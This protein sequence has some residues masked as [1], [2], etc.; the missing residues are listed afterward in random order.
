MVAL[1]TL[2]APAAAVAAAGG[3]PAAVELEHDRPVR[4][5]DADRPG[6]P[7]HGKV[8]AG[9]DECRPGLAE[10]GE[11]AIGRPA[12]GDATQVEPVPG[13]ERDAGGGAIDVDA[14]TAARRCC[15]WRPAGA[16]DEL[17]RPVV[18]GRGERV[19]DGRVEA[20]G[21]AF[22]G[23]HGELGELEQLSARRSARRVG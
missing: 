11:H 16:V 21:G 12:L 6:P 9:V 4:G 1:L 7:G 20:A 15:A 5:V 8:A 13:L 18:P 2:L 10:D 19:V 23:R 14:A 17:E 3:E 22:A